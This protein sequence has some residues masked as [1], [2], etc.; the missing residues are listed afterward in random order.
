MPQKKEKKLRK[1]IQGNRNRVVIA[2][3]VLTDIITISLAVVLSASI[4]LLLI[5]LMGGDI[6]WSLIFTGLF[7]FVIFN[8]LL[9]WINGLYPGFGLASVHEMQK[10]LYVVSLAS[11]FLGV[12][13]FLQQIANA[14]SRFIFLLTWF[15]SALFMIL[16]RFYLRNRF[17]RFSW[18]GIPMVVVGS[19]EN[20]TPIIKKLFESRRLG[21]RPVYYYDPEFQSNQPISGVEPVQSKEDLKNLAAEKGIKHVIF[22][23][24]LEKISSLNYHWMRDVFPNILFVLKLAPFGSLWVRTIDLH[25]PLA[26]ETY[27][28][29]LSKQEIII[30]RILDM[31]LSFV[32]LLVTL[33]IFLI[34]SILVRIDS[35]GPIFYKQK[36]LGL[37][38]KLF[39][40]L[41]FRTMHCNAD[42]ML[43]DLLEKDPEAKA[44][45]EEYHKLS[46][47]PRITRVGKFLRRYS[48][49]EI[50]QFI[51][52]IKGEMN[53]IGPRSY[54][55]R[56]QADMG[57]YARII[58]KVKPGITGWWQVMGRNETSFKERLELDEYYISNWSIW[59]DIYIILKTIWVI[60]SGQGL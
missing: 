30:K 46:N 1:A 31:I 52:V 53:L 55:P 9:A 14:Y 48:L 35:K 27:Y 29:L 21:F 4:R 54:L 50:P 23:D 22:T 57:D 25:G 28:H 11:V 7:F 2:L 36:R 10:L 49:D 16:G 6:N 42:Q 19:Q 3:L 40:S 47:D 8:I 59:L 26:I 34:L 60:I 38:G 18:W 24:S 15:L 33:H 37:N 44:E 17:S 13:L 41:K 58:L 45:Y 20:I 43:E 5:P 12:F 39:D 56:E 51:N 32:L